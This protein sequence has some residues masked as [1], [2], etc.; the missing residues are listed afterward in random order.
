MGNPEP[1]PARH[2]LVLALLLLLLASGS[3]LVAEEDP[4]SLYERFAADRENSSIISALTE[5]EEKLI[6]QFDNMS[7]GF[8]K[9]ELRN[10]WT[11]RR[12]YT[13]S[14][15][16]SLYFNFPDGTEERDAKIHAF[17][18]H[19]GFGRNSSLNLMV[20]YSISHLEHTPLRDSV[21]QKLLNQLIA[22]FL[23]RPSYRDH[24]RLAHIAQKI[25]EE[26]DPSLHLTALRALVLPQDGSEAD[27]QRVRALIR[28]QDNLFYRYALYMHAS[29]LEGNTFALRD[30]AELCAEL[31]RTSDG[32]FD[33]TPRFLF[34]LQKEDFPEIVQV[35]WGAFLE[36]VEK[37]ESELHRCPETGNW[38]W[39]PGAGEDGNKRD[40]PEM[41]GMPENN[42]MPR[43]DGMDGTGE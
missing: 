1:Y 11:E 27:K 25:L 21:T 38:R 40:R 33:L 7:Y 12:R 4:P 19:L 24:Q 5:E 29:R 26:R 22:L 32:E 28:A 23:D 10:Q 42:G 15:I 14:D 8:V 3:T 30:G 43:V 17:G 34:Y 36:F 35:D 31:E 16:F 13:R 18:N 2:A 9:M 39:T 6:E 37:H 41:P 20:T